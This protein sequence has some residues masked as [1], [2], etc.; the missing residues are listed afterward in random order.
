MKTVPVAVALLP[1]ATTSLTA[2]EAAPVPPGGTNLFE[3]IQQG[4]WAMWPLGLLMLGCFYLVFLCWT[5][6]TPQK[7]AAP[8]LVG[9]LTPALR[10]RDFAGARAI[11]ERHSTVLGR[12][13]AVALTKGRRDA[14]DGHREAM[15]T[16]FVEAAEGEENAVGQ[17]INYLN[18]IATVAPMVGLLGTVSGMIGA[19]QTISLGG[20]GKPEL[21]A[22]DIGEALITTATG[23][24]IGIPAMIGYFFYR[25]R[26]TA[27]MLEVGREGGALLDEVET[28][29]HQAPPAA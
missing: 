12:L 17:W 6:T 22:G 21:L 29:A 19:F 9:E 10:R 13:L 27:R 8:G 14:P 20:M 24:V 28:P 25:N 1:L 2:Q 18:V 16:A 11:A 7:F 15:E 5:L 3:L 23:L 4:G 26:L